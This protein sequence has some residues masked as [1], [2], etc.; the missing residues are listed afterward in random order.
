MST[1]YNV[2]SS[3]V[4]AGMV[5]CTYIKGSQIRISKLIFTSVPEDCFI[6][7]YANRADPDEMPHIVKHFIWV[8]TVCQ[9]QFHAVDAKRLKFEI[10]YLKPITGMLQSK[11]YLSSNEK[12]LYSA[13]F[14]IH[15]VKG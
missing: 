7:I 13:Q 1:Q 3:H 8:C 4:P 5:H 2:G 10:C 12:Y 11:S 6:Y 14:V 9:N 15:Q